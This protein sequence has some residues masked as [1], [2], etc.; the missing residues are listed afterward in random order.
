[1]SCLWLLS[2]FAKLL[3]YV[4]FDE[5]WEMTVL[6]D[7]TTPA[8]FWKVQWLYVQGV[9]RGLHKRYLSNEWWCCQDSL[10]CLCAF[11]S[12]HLVKQRQASTALKSLF[13]PCINSQALWEKSALISSDH[14]MVSTAWGRSLKALFMLYAPPADVQRGNDHKQHHD[15]AWD[16]FFFFSNL[17]CATR[18]MSVRE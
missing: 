1:M 2:R 10:S 12:N 15:R 6:D 16:Y 5:Q 9:L 11:I 7:E 18:T 14:V 8:K 13:Y 3:E 4:L 17:L